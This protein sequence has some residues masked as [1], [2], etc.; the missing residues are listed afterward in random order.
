M[1]VRTDIPIAQQIVQ[2]NHA[3]LEA[4]L[5]YGAAHHLAQTSSIILLAV[6]NEYQLLKAQAHV[7]SHNITT[8]AFFEPDAHL[9]YE[10]GFTAFATAPVAEE[11]RPLFK[12]IS[13]LEDER[14]L[15]CY[16]LRKFPSAN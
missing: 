16:H 6:K 5:A 1:F 7:N 2:S 11:C 8:H 14:P 15:R 13:T 9:G 4:G 12:K 10:P 3:A